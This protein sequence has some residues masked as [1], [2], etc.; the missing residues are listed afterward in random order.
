MLSSGIVATYTGWSIFSPRVLEPHAF[1][2]LP[3]IQILSVC[4]QLQ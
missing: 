4:L 2:H 3:H 1:T